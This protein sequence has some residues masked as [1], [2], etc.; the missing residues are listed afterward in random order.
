MMSISYRLY[1]PDRLAVLDI[2][3]YGKEDNYVI[4]RINVPKE[5]R[6]QGWGRALLQ[7]AI[8]IADD[9]G[10]TLWLEINPYGEMTFQQLAAWYERNGFKKV[11]TGVYKR[12]PK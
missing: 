3:E 10:Y 5:H 9:S 6:G 1:N 8:K 7:D 2:G 11:S 4:T 12:K